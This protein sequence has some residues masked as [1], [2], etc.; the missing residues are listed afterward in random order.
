MYVDASAIV[1]ILARE[2]EASDLLAVLERSEP[3][4]RKTSPVAVFEAVFGLA[5][6]FQC[7]IADARV[8]VYDFLDEAEIAIESIDKAHA[9]LAI[10][11]MERFGKGR[12]PAALNMGDCFGYAV[13]K[14][15]RTSILFKGDDF[16]RTDLLSARVNP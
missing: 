2:T 4:Q 16:S 15:A 8:A 11:A 9:E 12:H 1:A 10:L 14:A 7:P 6:I 13:A 3:G 5:R